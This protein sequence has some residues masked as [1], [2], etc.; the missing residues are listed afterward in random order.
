MRRQVAVPVLVGG[1]TIALAAG[2]GLAWAGWT[3]GGSAAVVT[4]ESARIPVMGRPVAEL[5]GNSAKISWA[6]VQ[7]SSGRP[8]GGYVV[9]R[10]D[11]ADSA[12]ACTAAAN[13]THCRDRAARPGSTLTYVVHATAGANWVGQDSQPSDPVGI[14][15]AANVAG[16]NHKTGG[17]D[18]A[19]AATETRPVQEENSAAAGPTPAAT[20][21][22]VPSEPVSP[23]AS[24]SGSASP[25]APGD[26][27]GP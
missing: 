14:P 9:L 7:L 23:A 26:A 19:P 8:V 2:G 13:H 25:A 12:V 4:A 22:P 24:P 18:Q 16:D 10:Q 17:T 5:S 15:D 11:G 20:T 3:V 21:D 1:A 27:G 6:E